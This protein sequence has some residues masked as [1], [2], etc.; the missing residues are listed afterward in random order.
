M[1]INEYGK[2]GHGPTFTLKNGRVKIENASKFKIDGCEK[3][4]HG[5][6]K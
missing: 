6:T 4:Y 5:P 1:E 2:F 3:L